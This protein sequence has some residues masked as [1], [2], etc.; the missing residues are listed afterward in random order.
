MNVLYIVDQSYQISMIVVD[1]SRNFK[2]RHLV[3]GGYNREML[4][5]EEEITVRN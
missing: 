1:H 5:Q 3:D 4:I 2:E